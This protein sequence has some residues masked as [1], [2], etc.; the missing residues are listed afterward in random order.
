MGQFNSKAICLWPHGFSFW[1][2]SWQRVLCILFFPSFLAMIWKA[3]LLSQLV[4]MSTSFK[5]LKKRKKRQVKKHSRKPV[6]Y[7]VYLPILSY[8]KLCHLMVMLSSLYL[9]Q[10]ATNRE[11]KGARKLKVTC[12][13]FFFFLNCTCM[14]FPLEQHLDDPHSPK[15]F[16]IWKWRT[17]H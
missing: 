7:L 16:G 13:F 9:K 8:M 5:K 15:I 14:L 6:R 12:M 11:N 10:I 1:H 4:L 2:W 3:L 17:P